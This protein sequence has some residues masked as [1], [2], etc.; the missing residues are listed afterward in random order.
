MGSNGDGTVLDAQALPLIID[1]AQAEG[2]EVV[3]LRQFL[4]PEHASA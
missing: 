4:L 3:D 1:G 2:Y